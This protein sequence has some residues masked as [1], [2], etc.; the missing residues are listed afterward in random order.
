MR[1]GKSSVVLVVI[2]IMA[3]FYGSGCGKEDTQKEVDNRLTVE[4]VAVE[5]GRAY[6]KRSTIRGALRGLMR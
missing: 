3:L 1:R 6:I 2:L 4:T 5:P